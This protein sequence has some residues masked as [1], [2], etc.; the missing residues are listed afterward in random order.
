MRYSRPSRSLARFTHLGGV[1]SFLNIKID[2]KAVLVRFKAY[3]FGAAFR[4]L[5][6]N[7]RVTLGGALPVGR[8]WLR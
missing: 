3:G 5:S 7:N 4:P 8:A 6:D 2:F 1:V